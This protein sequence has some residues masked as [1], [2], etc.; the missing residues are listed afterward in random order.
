MLDGN[1]VLKL[2]SAVVLICSSLILS[3]FIPY[4]VIKIERFSAVRVTTKE[5]GPSTESTNCG[6]YCVAIELHCSALALIAKST[7]GREIPL[8]F[9]RT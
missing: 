3:P 9:V 6:M 1:G 2:I 4:A 7:C 5:K 8:H